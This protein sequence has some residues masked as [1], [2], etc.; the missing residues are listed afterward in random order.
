VY[1]FCNAVVSF[2]R[3]AKIVVKLKRQVYCGCWM[4]RHWL[5]QELTS[6]LLIS[7]TKL[8]ELMIR[9]ANVSHTMFSL[10]FISVNV[11]VTMCPPPKKK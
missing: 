3:L 2:G 10:L 1:V 11:N 4:K 8:M 9:L 5:L 7:S 6:H